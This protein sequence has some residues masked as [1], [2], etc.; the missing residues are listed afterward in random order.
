MTHCSHGAA[1]KGALLHT[2]PVKAF[3]LSAAIWFSSN[4]Q[5]QRERWLLYLLK[6]AEKAKPNIII[7]ENV[8]NMLTKHTQVLIDIIRKFTSVSKLATKIPIPA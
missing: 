1:L 8:R 7:L 3:P 5:H 6:Y 2:V 4:S